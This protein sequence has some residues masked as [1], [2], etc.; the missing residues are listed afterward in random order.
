MSRK[1][2]IGVDL[3][4]TKIATGIVDMDAKLLDQV[5]MDTA[6]QEGVEAVLGRMAESVRTLMDRQGVKAEDVL[7]IGVCSPGPL[8][9]ETGIVLAAPN[10]GWTN[11][12]L[13]PMLQELT[14]ITTYVEN[15]ANAAALAEK[16]MGAGRGAKN[17]V[18]ITVSTGVGSG[19]I[20][21]GSLYAGSH[22]TAGEVGHIVME[23]GGPLCGCGQRGCL[24]AYASGTAIARMAREALESGTQSKIR[25][26]VEDNLEAVSAKVVGE[27][28]AQGDEVANAILDK[29]FHYLGLGMISVINLFDPELIVIGGGVSKL[30]DRLFKPVIE[31]VRTRAVAG[32]R[33]K[34]RIVPAE[35]GVDAGML[36]ACALVLDI[37]GR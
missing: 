16:W 27:A 19:I 18:Y 20:I 21:N 28:A 2:A 26:L 7:G 22:G 13:G 36:G 5:V 4:G 8:D 9:R 3:G 12:H 23:D 24:E 32:P 17:M 31:M 25:D 35:L 15:D 29:A 33:E 34:T 14:G 11:V 30:G 1:Y 10:L 6:A 37:A